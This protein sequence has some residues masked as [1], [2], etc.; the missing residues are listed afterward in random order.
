M[1]SD[2]DIKQG[3]QTGDVIINN[4]D[5]ARL[6]PATYDVLLGNDFM[7]F[8]RHRIDVIDPKQS[9][10]D[11]MTKIHIPD[12]EAFILHP[13]E[14][15]LG[16]ID[17]Y[18]GTSNKLACEVLG[19]SSLARLGLIVHTTAGFIDPGNALNITLEF[20]NTNSL[21]IKLYPKMKIAQMAF[22]RLDTPA[23]RAYGDKAL[24]SKYLNNRGVKASDMWRNFQEKEVK[25]KVSQD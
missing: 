8:D 16:V 15:A 11:K 4:F 1:L 5:P 21:P 25:E 10:E 12:G 17:D 23:E 13:H 6:Q 18:V 22:M 20:Y 2:A 7:I 24:G 19:K 9:M 14:F 3:L